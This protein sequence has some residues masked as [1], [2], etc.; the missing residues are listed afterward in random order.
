[1][2]KILLISALF[3]TPAFAQ[4]PAAQPSEYQLKVTPAEVD[5]LSEGLQ[6]QPFGKVFP[7]INKLREQIIAQ[8]PKPETKPV[9]KPAEKKE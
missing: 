4:Q 1:M 2:K 8:Q 6:T 7:L 9:D 5:L 3:V